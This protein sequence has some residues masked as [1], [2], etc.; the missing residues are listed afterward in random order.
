MYRLA[1]LGRFFFAVPMVAFGV[2]HF[3]YL[4]FVTRVFPKLPAWIPGHHYL[5]F[6]SGLFLFAAGFSIMNSQAARLTALLLGAV[7]LASFTTLYLPLLI[8]TPPNGGLWTSAG[9]ALALSGGSFLV[10]GSLPEKAN[11]PLDAFAIASLVKFLEEFIALGRF[12]F[13]AFLILCGVEHFIYVEFVAAMVPSWIPWHIFWAYFAGVALIA[14]GLGMVLPKTN[15]PMTTQLAAFLSGI[16]IFIWVLIVHIP[17]AAADLSNANE[18][19]AV[20]E[21]L[22]MSGTAFLAAASIRNR[23][24][25]LP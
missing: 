12:F 21:A 11:G 25:Q 16:M 5:A 22:A 24:H 14:G 15:W 20:F 7:I 23:H 3:A 13:A 17:R 4:D 19:T 2:Q 8:T 9:K 18:M 10:A 6:I 1:E